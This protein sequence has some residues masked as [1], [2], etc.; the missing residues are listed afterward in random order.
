MKI[1]ARDK[2]FLIAGVIAVCLFVFLK[3]LVLPFYDKLGQ[4]KKDIELQQQTLE[5]YKKFIQKQ[6]E[7][8]Q[9][10]KKLSSQEKKIQTSLLKGETASLAAADIQKIIDNIAEKSQVRVKSVKVM[11]P[12]EKEGLETIPIQITFES[13]LEKWNSFINSIETNRKLLTIPEL[14][15]RVKNKR[16]PRAISVT[17]KIV[18]FKQKKET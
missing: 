5:K 17:L 3:F 13:D 12:N 10:L 8:Q 2:K 9:E 16:K 11:D 15:I 14:K 6:S 1:T 18:G 7:V 4:Q